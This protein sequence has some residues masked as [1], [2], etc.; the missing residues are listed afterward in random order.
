MKAASTPSP[1][2]AARATTSPRSKSSRTAR[3]AGKSS[4]RTS[5]TPRHSTP[6][7]G[8]RSCF[9]DAR[10]RTSSTR[11][12]RRSG[13]RWSKSSAW[14]RSRVFERTCSARETSFASCPRRRRTKSGRTVEPWLRDPRKS[15]TRRFSPTSSRSARC[16]VSNPPQTLDQVVDPSWLTAA[17]GASAAA[18]EASDRESLLAEIKTLSPPGL[19]QGVLSKPGTTSCPPTVRGFCRAPR[20]CGRRNA[21]SNPGR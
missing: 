2:W 17:V 10:S 18:S 7:A 5:G 11:P 19:R 4:S 15:A 3:S 21:S 12:R 8:K 16:S 9:A 20:W 1:T 14:T 13:K 6:S